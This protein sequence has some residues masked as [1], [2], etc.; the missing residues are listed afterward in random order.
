MSVGII[1]GL[2]PGRAMTINGDND[3]SVAKSA[4]S[5]VP[6]SGEIPMRK[7]RNL[8]SGCCHGRGVENK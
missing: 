6:G 4:A 2:L 7:A 3:T 8:S 5:G 1:P